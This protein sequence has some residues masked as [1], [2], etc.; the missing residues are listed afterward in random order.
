MTDYSSKN[1]VEEQPYKA[2]Y[3]EALLN[4][5]GLTVKF[6]QF[7]RGNWPTSNATHEN[8]LTDQ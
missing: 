2:T 1:R 7:P 6:N 8:T 3:I 4:R 5:L